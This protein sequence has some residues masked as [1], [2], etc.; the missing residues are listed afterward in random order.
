MDVAFNLSTRLSFIHNKFQ[1]LRIQNVKGKTLSWG[2]FPSFPSN[3]RSINISRRHHLELTQ[4]VAAF[5]LFFSHLLTWKPQGKAKFPLYCEENPCY[6]RQSH[7]EIEEYWFHF[8]EGDLKHT[9]HKKRVEK[10][11]HNWAVQSWKANLYSWVLYLHSNN[12]NYLTASVSFMPYIRRDNAKRK[13][14]SCISY[15][16][17]NTFP[18]A[19][20]FTEPWLK[21]SNS[22]WFQYSLECF[23]SCLWQAKPC[24]FHLWLACHNFYTS[25]ET[26]IFIARH[27]LKVPSHTE[28]WGP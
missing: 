7:N 12:K 5:C 18:V 19:I 13:A 16:A 3:S 25:W 9:T 4:N 26:L 8:S 24:H 10:L 22:L 1:Q 15:L 14:F 6:T 27:V 23:L 17:E 28:S 20:D 21:S 2:W 11:K